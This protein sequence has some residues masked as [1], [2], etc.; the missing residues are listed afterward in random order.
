MPALRLLA[1][2]RVP[3]KLPEVYVEPF[4]EHVHWL[5]AHT[6][7]ARACPVVLPGL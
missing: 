6:A 4:H 2:G 5:E 7:V 1:G 3:A